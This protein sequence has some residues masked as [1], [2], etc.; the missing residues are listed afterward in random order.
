MEVKVKTWIENNGQVVFGEG[1]KE[2]LQLIEKT[3]SLN[4]AAKELQMSYRAAWGKIKDTEK[5]LGFPLLT[6]QTGGAAG[7]GS[8]L[9]DRARKWLE[10]FSRLEETLNKSAQH[11][12]DTLFSKVK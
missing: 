11:E 8:R 9:T 7:G 4:K 10:A 2:L 3:G 5:R 1:R 6:T 12:F